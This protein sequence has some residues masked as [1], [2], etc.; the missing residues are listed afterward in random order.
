MARKHNVAVGEKTCGERPYHSWDQEKKKWEPPHEKRS[1]FTF[2][3][4]I[5]HFGRTPFVFS[6][7][8]GDDRAGINFLTNPADYNL[9]R[10]SILQTRNSAVKSR[11]QMPRF[12]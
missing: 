1:R 4:S 2:G 10:R 5:V 11:A 7:I 6:L 9:R 3:R 8:P 12:L